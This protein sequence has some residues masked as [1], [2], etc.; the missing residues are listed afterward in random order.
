MHCVTGI[1]ID[2]AQLDNTGN[3]YT[4]YSLLEYI[5]VWI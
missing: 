5:C 3:S 4:V 2:T 1:V